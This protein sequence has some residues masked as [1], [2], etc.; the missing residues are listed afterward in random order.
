MVLV[1]DGEVNDLLFAFDEDVVDRVVTI[2]GVLDGHILLVEI[3]GE[4]PNRF[5]GNTECNEI[6]VQGIKR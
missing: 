4:F 2:L 5:F 1:Q 3:L 6:G